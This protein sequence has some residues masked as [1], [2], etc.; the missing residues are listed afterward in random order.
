MRIADESVNRRHFGTT[1]A[2]FTL[3]KKQNNWQQFPERVGPHSL[4]FIVCC[5]LTNN[6]KIQEE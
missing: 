6:I 4:L 2:A 5:H 3:Q 1:C